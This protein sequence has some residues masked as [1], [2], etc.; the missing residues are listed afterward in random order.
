MALTK[1]T[2]QVIKN[3]TDVTV[4]V[5]TVTNTLAVGGTVSIGGTLTYEDVTN[6]DSVGL[7]TARNGI[8]VG[9]GITLSKDGDVFFT[10]IATGN[11][12]GLTAL[13]AS[14]LASG[15]VPTA[16]L[17]SGTASSSTFLRGDSTFQTVST[18]LVDD[19]SP[20]LGG[21]LD[22]NSKTINL[23]DSSGETVNRIRLGADNDGDL[24]HDGTD[25]LLR[26]VDSGQILLRSDGAKVFANASGSENQAVFTASGSVSLYHA[27]TIK[28]STSSTGVT[29][30]GGQL[31]LNRQDTSN[32]GGEIVFNRASDNTNQWFNDVY[33]NDSTAKIRWHHGGAEK[34]SFSTG[35]DLNI[36]DGN[37]H[38]ASGHGIDFSATS[39]ASGASNELLDDYEEGTWTP[40]FYCTNN[41][42][43]VTYDGGAHHGHYRKI[44]NLVFATFR[45]YWS[46]KSGNGNFNVGNLPYTSINDTNQS[47]PSGFSS[48]YFSGMGSNNIT[49]YLMNNSTQVRIGYHTNGGFGNQDFSNLASAGE[50]NGHITYYAD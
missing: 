26:E 15:T 25:L 28:L 27:G 1:V 46:S 4:G 21:N 7:V 3:T 45:M 20:Q 30:E 29:I 12:S 50:Y 18:D 41:S 38:V 36:I 43:T 31:A 16:R 35:G 24:F 37:L 32:E 23:G 48:H 44:G 8:V 33:G 5:L 19:T 10:G 40:Y 6:I 17:G 39:D 34:I 22:V 14:N 11:G 49:G 13:N 42:Q 9:S 2:G 47:Q